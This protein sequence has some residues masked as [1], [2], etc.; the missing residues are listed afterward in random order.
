MVIDDVRRLHRALS[1]LEIPL[2]DEVITEAS[3]TSLRERCVFDPDTMSPQRALHFSKNN[4]QTIR[5]QVYVSRAMK[6][7]FLQSLCYQPTR[8]A[9]RHMRALNLFGS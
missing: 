8:P 4:L 2:P 6:T 9:S 3:V 1:D 5:I 7:Q